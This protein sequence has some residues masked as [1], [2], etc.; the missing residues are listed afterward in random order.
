M[1]TL[2]GYINHDVNSKKARAPNWSMGSKPTTKIENKSPGPASVGIEKFTRNG[3]IYS[4]AYSLYCKTKELSKKISYCGN[5][6]MTMIN[7]F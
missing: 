1:R 3:K 4:P 6:C 7:F 2:V 5:K